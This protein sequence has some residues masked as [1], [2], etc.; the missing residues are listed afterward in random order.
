MKLI[1]CFILVCLL[2]QNITCIS[3]TM[4]TGYLLEMV[5]KKKS[6]MSQ[7]PPHSI[8]TSNIVINTA[9]QPNNAT[10]NVV[11]PSP[12]PPGVSPPI[13]TSPA[14]DPT[15]I[16]IQVSVP[17]I[18]P[19]PI[20][21]PGNAIPTQV[22]VITPNA[23]TSITPFPISS[24]N[25]EDKN[26]I[27]FQGWIKYFRFQTVDIKNKPK[28]FFKNIKFDKQTTTNPQIDEVYI[29]NLV[30]DICNT[31]RETFLWNFA[32]RLFNDL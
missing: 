5:K 22:P 16:P 15:A 3:S 2:L 23:P 25:E 26:F 31:R 11:T 9:A 17:A 21:V 18:Q 20:Q 10:P 7:V 13:P 30:W 27:Y 19:A 6:E 1:I 8:E 14:P 12:T 32:E 4:S 24:H 28:N 29:F